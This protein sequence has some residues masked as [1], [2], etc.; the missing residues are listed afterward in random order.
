M[1]TSLKNKNLLIVHALDHYLYEYLFKLTP[2]LKKKGFKVSVLVFDEKIFAQYKSI[3]IAAEYFPKY[4][5]LAYK[6]NRFVILRPVAWIA[7]YFWTFLNR[8]NYD[9]AVVPWDNKMIYYAILRG[10]ESITVHNTTNFIDLELELAEQKSKKDHFLMKKIESIFKVNLMPRFMEE[11]T[12]HGFHWYIDKLM[13]MRSSSLIQGFSGIELMTV[14]GDQIKKNLTL[15]GLNNLPSIH[16]IGNPS[17]EGYLGYARDFSDL[18]KRETLESLGFS[19]DDRMFTLFLSPSKFTETMIKEIN[20]VLSTIRDYSEEAAVCLKFHPKTNE[21]D[22]DQITKML[23]SLIDKHHVIKDFTG[24]DY[25]L[26]LVL[27]SEALI[28]KQSTIGYI[29]MLTRIPI[30]S[31]NILDTEYGDEMYKVLGCSFHAETTEELK[32]N[33]KKLDNASELRKLFEQQKRA[34]KRFCLETD[35]PLE[36]FSEV[37]S[38]FLTK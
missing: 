22:I 36:N 28:Q 10:I 12:R 5:R 8:S 4:V 16:V 2:F 23:H 20:L 14:T 35:S 31:Y 32:N 38:S 9:L 18:K 3:G 27:S 13:G 1:A 7:C 33:L 29:A 19:R 30:V 21:I 34:C 24:D 11:I 25:N 6:L 17:Y 15:A 26:D 37:V